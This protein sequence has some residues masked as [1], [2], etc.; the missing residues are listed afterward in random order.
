MNKQLKGSL[1]TIWIFCVASIGGWAQS[2]KGDLIRIMVSPSKPDMT[3]R[4]NQPITFNISIYKFGQLVQGAE[5]KYAI[6]LEKM[7]PIVEDQVILDSGTTSISADALDQP[8]FLR[9]IVSY[10][11]NGETYSNSGTAAVEP[12]KIVPTVPYPDDFLAFWQKH[13]LEMGEIPLEPEMTLMPD[14]CTDRSNVYHVSFRNADG[15]IYGILSMP[16]VEGK[17][18]AILNVPGAGVRPYY[19]SFL[20]EDVISLQ[21]GI[22]GIP[23]N[24]YDSEVYDNLRHGALNGYWRSNLDDPEMYYFKR[25]Y[26]GCVRAVDFIHSLPAFDGQ[27]LGIIGGSQGGALSI[28]TAGLD[29]RIDYLMSF[30]PALCDLTGYLH[31]RAGGWPH[32]FRDEFTNEADKINTAPYYDVINFAR[33]VKAEGLYSFGYNDNV[34][35]PTSIYAAYNVVNVT[36]G[37]DLYKDGAHWMYPEQLA[38]GQKW[39]LDK[40]S[41]PRD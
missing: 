6:G 41:V 7:D 32:L 14:A 36:K 5:I 29:D 1:I 38:A 13:I 23:V 26:L 40:L 15:H 18:P 20:N 22:H 39:L 30:Y 3:Y 27:N 34:C 11:E 28:I 8:G 19:G 24:L 33:Q 25:V 21:I 12:D 37:L 17:Y 4:I 16:K 9:C 35:P 10:E 2:Q 31:G